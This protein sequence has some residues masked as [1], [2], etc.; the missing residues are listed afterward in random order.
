ML[1]YIA[2]MS[3]RPASSDVFHAIA[4]PTR[5]RLL[6]RLAEGETAMGDLAEP[7]A[8]TLGA[9]SQHLKVLRDAGLVKERRA[10]RQRFYRVDPAPLREVYDWIAHF[11][12]F[13]PQKLRALG[14]YLEENP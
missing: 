12:R 8:M 6:N 5:R 10:G 14:R 7:F 1:K 3:R 9:V 13:W 11:E 4:D 2:T